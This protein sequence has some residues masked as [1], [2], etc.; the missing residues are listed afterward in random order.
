MCVVPLVQV[1]EDGDDPARLR[2]NRPLRGR[3]LHVT[4]L[5]GGPPSYAV[6]GTAFRDSPNVTVKESE[7]HPRKARSTIDTTYDGIVTDVSDAQPRRRQRRN[8]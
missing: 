2:K 7:V 6:D 8:A 5:A 4:G 3:R 1:P